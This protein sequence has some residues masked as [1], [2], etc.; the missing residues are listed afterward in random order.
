MFVV[1]GYDRNATS[2]HVVYGPFASMKEADEWAN[3][4]FVNKLWNIKK[5]I[6]A[7]LY[8]INAGDRNP[9]ND[10]C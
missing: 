8:H 3:V 9:E 4:F 2:K 1:L 6:E 7:R 10:G 5:V